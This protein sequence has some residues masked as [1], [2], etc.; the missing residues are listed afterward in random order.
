MK[1]GLITLQN[2]YSYGASLQALATYEVYKRLGCDVTF[3]NYVN[4]HE[5]NQN[6]L[7]SR[8][9]DISPI[10]NIIYTIEN[11]F[12]GQLRNRKRAFDDFHETLVKTRPYTNINEMSELEY[13]VMVSGSDQLWNPAIFGEIDTAYF[14]NFGHAGL[15]M[16]YAASCGSHVYSEE[17]WGKILPLLERYDAISTREDFLRGQLQKRFPEKRIMKVLDPTLLLSKDEWISEFGKVGCSASNLREHYILV[18]MINV[19]YKEYKRRYAHIVKYCKEKL[20]LKAY[21]ISFNSMFIFY[22]CDRNITCATPYDLIQLINNADLVIT[23]SF[24]GVAFSI[25]LNTKFI[26]L[27]TSNPK[28]VEEL[29]DVTGLLNRLVDKFDARQCKELLEN[30]DFTFANLSLKRKRHGSLQWIMDQISTKANMT[31]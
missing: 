11:I 22:G 13:D 12:M 14:L 9:S 30:I 19:P 17:E 15:R 2:S 3:V 1:V 28:R 21:A 25:N 27:Q 7:I 20:G 5:Q 10:K 26:A 8:R 4:C 29:L 16:A 24:H 6:H 18:Y 23:S 31:I